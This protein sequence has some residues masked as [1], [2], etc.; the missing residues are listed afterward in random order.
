LGDRAFY[1]VGAPSVRIQFAGD[2]KSMAMTV[3]DPQPVLV[4]RKK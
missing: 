1:P 3:S 4:A 2:E